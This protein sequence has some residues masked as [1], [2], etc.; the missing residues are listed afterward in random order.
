MRAP[1]VHR[2]GPAPDG[3]PPGALLKLAD[4]LE[5]PAVRSVGISTTQDGRWALYVVVRGTTEV[6]LL[7]LEAACD[8]FPVVYAAAPDHP[9]RA[10]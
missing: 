8:G 4:R 1:K 3:E 10:Y 6:P 9:A 2:P 7:D 5:H